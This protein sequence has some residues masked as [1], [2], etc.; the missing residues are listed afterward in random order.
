MTALY[1]HD[2]LVSGNY[3]VYYNPQKTKGFEERFKKNIS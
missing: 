3:I 1:I 2:N